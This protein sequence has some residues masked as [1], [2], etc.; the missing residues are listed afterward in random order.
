MTWI[1]QDFV[2]LEEVCP[3]IKLEVSYSKITN[4][5][6]SIVPGYHSA[7][8]YLHKIPALALKEAHALAK[9]KGLGFLI[10]DAYRPIKAVQFFIDW[11]RKPEDNLMYKEMF[12]PK[13]S[14]SELFEK[15]FIAKHSS[16]SRGSAVDLTL[17]E[18][19]SGE[20]LDMG[21]RFD[22]FDEIS[23]TESHLVSKVQLDNRLILKN[24]MESC[25]FKN[26]SQEWWHYSFRPEPYP[27]TYFDFDIL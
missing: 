10:F 7:K 4:F 15:G 19:K 5:T 2:S 27:E 26:F 17:F 20:V 9:G 14:R 13:F 24:I 25:G 23:Q 8:A 16:H 11:A 22:F 6:G 3:G 21:S 1:H 12:Y 18:N